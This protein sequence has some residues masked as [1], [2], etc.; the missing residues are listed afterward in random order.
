MFAYVDDAEIFEGDH[1]DQIC[2]R[3]ALSPLVQNL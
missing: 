2:A 1:S 3:G